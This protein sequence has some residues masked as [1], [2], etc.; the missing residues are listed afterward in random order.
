MLLFF[1]LPY[2]KY[3]VIMSVATTFLQTTKNT[4]RLLSV[5]SATY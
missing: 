2:Y 4:S 3:H 1:G 5:I